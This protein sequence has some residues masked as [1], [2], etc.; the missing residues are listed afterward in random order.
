MFR[1]VPPGPSGAG[2]DLWA[3][4]ADSPEFAELRRRLLRFVLPATAGF[5]VWFFAFIGLTAWA[6]E[7]MST[8]V[9]GD[10]TLV[11]VLAVAQFVSTFALTAA[12][13][14][15]ANRRLDPLADDIRGR[16]EGTHL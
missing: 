3:T 15:Y 7:L 5:L 1:P 4:A 10:L 12:Y 16:L 9:V 8:R 6:P 13:V 2:R 11:L 14:R